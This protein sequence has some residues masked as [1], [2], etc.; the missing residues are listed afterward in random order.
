H[1]DVH[2]RSFIRHSPFIV[3]A[4]SDGVGSAD[5]SPRGD[6]AGFVEVL[7]NQHLLIPDR[8]GNNRLD[9][10]VNI[11]ACPYVGVIFFIPGIREVLR[12]NGIAAIVRDE[13]LLQPLAIAGRAPPTGI[14]IEVR[15]MFLHCAKS[16]MRS[17]LWEPAH[18]PPRGVI[19][20]AG[21]MLADHIKLNMTAADVD[22]LL[23]EGQRNLY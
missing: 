16:L 2:S 20:S 9:S 13:A 1:L 18:W 8:P 19:A 12:V 7:D 6:P 10:M 14:L 15:E 22:A 17:R 3:L 11:L 5:A 23:E 21:Q 4:T